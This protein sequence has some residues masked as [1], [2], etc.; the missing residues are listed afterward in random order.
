[1]DNVREFAVEW[2]CTIVQT[3]VIKL[4]LEWKWDSILLY[5]DHDDKNAMIIGELLPALNSFTS[6]TVIQSIHYPIMISYIKKLNHNLS[7]VQS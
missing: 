5:F 6:K 2:V 4:P 3:I 7:I 1:M